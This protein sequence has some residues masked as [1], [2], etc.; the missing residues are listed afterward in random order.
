MNSQSLSTASEFVFFNKS[1]GDAAAE[2]HFSYFRITSMHCAC[3]LFKYKLMVA[4]LHQVNSLS[5]D[6]AVRTTVLG[7]LLL[8]L[9]KQLLH[10]CHL[11]LSIIQASIKFACWLASKE[12]EMAL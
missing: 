8:T 6:P 3:M 7:Y 10:L 9:G 2:L 5:A 12:R 11:L 1:G 4:M